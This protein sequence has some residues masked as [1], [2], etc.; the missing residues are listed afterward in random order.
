M[1]TTTKL[2][3]AL[4]G[5]MLLAQCAKKTIPVITATPEEQIAA[6]KNKYTTEDIAKGETIYDR[7]CIKCHEPRQPG[8]FK[9]REW[10]KILPTMFKRAALNKDDAGLVQAWILTNAKP[11]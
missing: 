8:E 5:L 4:T 3:C 10:N 2:L 7:K 6:I 9:I 1:K 11:A